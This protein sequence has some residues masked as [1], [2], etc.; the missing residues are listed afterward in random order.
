MSIRRETLHRWHQ[1]HSSW[2]SSAI[3]PKAVTGS[4]RVRLPVI[5]PLRLPMSIAPPERPDFPPVSYEDLSLFR[6]IVTRQ[7]HR[8]AMR[9]GSKQRMHWAVSVRGLARSG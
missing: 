2:P 1:A 3:S 9:S 4:G 8:A 7:T 6:S 5:V